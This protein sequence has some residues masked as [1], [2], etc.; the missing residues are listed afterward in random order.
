MKDEFDMDLARLFMEKSE[1]PEGEAFVE[2]V[3]RRIAQ[4]R[5]VQRVML[6][7]LAIAGTAI[8]ALLTPGLIRLTGKAAD[9]SK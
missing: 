6:I 3:S 8:L 1:P 4:R 5:R 9:C 7:L 2:R